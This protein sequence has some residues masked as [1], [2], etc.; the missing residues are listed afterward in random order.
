[1]PTA[2]GE[3]L[4][5]SARGNVTKVR[6]RFERFATKVRMLENNLCCITDLVAHNVGSAA[7]AVGINRFC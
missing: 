1:M 3:H 7:A 6:R 5:T 2:F 4:T